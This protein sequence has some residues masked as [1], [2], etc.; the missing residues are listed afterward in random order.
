MN[1]AYSSRCTLLLA[2]RLAE[3]M[4]ERGCCGTCQ[5]QSISFRAPGFRPAT[6]GTLTANC[7]INCRMYTKVAVQAQVAAEASERRV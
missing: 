5:I 3:G 6:D 2:Y 4:T 1:N 7:A